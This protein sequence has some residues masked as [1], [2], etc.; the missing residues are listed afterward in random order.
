MCLLLIFDDQF[1]HTN[2]QKL[3][4]IINCVWLCFIAEELN[5]FCVLLYRRDLLVLQ[6]EVYSLL[7]L[8]WKAFI[9]AINI[10]YYI[11]NK[12]SSPAHI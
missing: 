5:F 7:F 1:N 10:T 8:V 11:K 6:S 3:L 12:Q 9:F 2:K 4:Y